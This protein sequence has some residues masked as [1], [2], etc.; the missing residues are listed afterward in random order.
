MATSAGKGSGLSRRAWVE[1]AILVG[2]FLGV[3]GFTF[4]YAQGL[5]YMSSD[6][7]AC[8]NCHIMQPQYDSWQK[9]S[10]HTV[11]TCADCHLPHDFVGKWLAK[12]ENGYHHSKAFTFQDFHEPI[13]ITAANA[14]VLQGSCLH[15]HG[16]LV[17]QQ[18]A[19]GAGAR[20]EIECVHCHRTV[21]H[22]ETTGLGRRLSASGR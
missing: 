18:V 9:A 13:M 21:G 11:A 19:G 8:V 3:G 2:L 10:H 4:L 14:R 7:K 17:H 12:A 5:S 16:A 20:G 15:C 22:G 6:P 1:L